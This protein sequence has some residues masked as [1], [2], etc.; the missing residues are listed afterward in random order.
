MNTSELADFVGVN[1]PGE[2]DALAVLADL[3]SAGDVIVDTSRK[4]AKDLI[5]SV[6]TMEFAA[7]LT[8]MK[9]AADSDHPLAPIIQ[10]ARDQLA[11]EG[12]DMSD[13][14]VQGACDLLV[15][16][17]GLDAAV[18]A[19]LKTLGVTAQKKWQQHGLD[20]L[21][22]EDEVTSAIAHFNLNDKWQLKTT[23]VGSL[24][25]NGTIT[26]WAGVISYM[27]S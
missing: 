8:A 5:A 27:G 12:L 7:L 20:A 21:P 23:E 16:T 1:Y 15:T 19:S 2:S 3:D 14:T 25:Q 9:D 4:R 24:I 13:P 10:I 22:T 6:G 11:S 17:F 18:G 26:D